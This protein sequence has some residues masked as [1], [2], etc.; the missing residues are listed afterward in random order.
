MIHGHV[1]FVCLADRCNGVSYR[2]GE[3][4]VFQ[5]DAIV[6]TGLSLE[7]EDAHSKNPSC[8]GAAILWQANAVSVIRG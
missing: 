7:N 3:L 1:S 4:R 8:N 2:G 5:G 6:C